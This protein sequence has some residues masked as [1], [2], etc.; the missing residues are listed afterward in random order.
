MPVVTIGGFNASVYFSGLAPGYAGLYQMNL[1]IPAGVGSGLQ[2]VQIMI[3]GF[4]S[5]VATIAIQ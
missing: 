5:N 3:G 1:Q 2:S 4:T